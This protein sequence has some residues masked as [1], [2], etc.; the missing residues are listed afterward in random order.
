SRIGPR[1][2]PIERRR[3]VGPR[4]GSIRPGAPS[5]ATPTGTNATV[6]NS[7]GPPLD[8]AGAPLVQSAASHRPGGPAVSR[9]LGL[10]ALAFL[11]GPAAA[12]PSPERVAGWVRDLES[13]SAKVWRPALDHLW[14]AGKAAEPALRA[15]QKHADADVRLRARLVLA[16]F[17]WGIFP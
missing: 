15:A 2:S 11:A 10:L 5:W 1:A 16:K 9:V 17:D 13:E 4:R 8:A 7:R 6:C 12:E 3:R 14:K